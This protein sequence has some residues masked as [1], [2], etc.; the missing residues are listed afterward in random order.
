M[1]ARSLQFLQGNAIVGAT[2]FRKN[3]V[4]AAD[5]GRSEWTRTPNTGKISK[6]EQKMEENR[7]IQYMAEYE[8][9][10]K[11]AEILNKEKRSV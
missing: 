4:A 2:T 9:N 1:P 7:K 5:A 8:K 3:A 6:K 10:R 11:Q